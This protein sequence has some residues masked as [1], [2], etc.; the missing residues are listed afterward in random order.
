VVRDLYG[1]I[2][3]LVPDTVSDALIEELRKEISQ[4]LGHYAAQREILIR[5]FENALD[6]E[7]LRIDPRALPVP[8]YPTMRVIDRLA[9][10]TDWL[11]E[12]ATVSTGRRFTFFSVKGGVGRSTAAAVTAWRLAGEGRKILV[13]D[14]DLEAPGIG[15]MLLAENRLPPLGTIDWLIEDGLGAADDV[16]TRDIIARSDIVRGQSELLVIPAFGERSL[17]VP[18]EYLAK[19]GRAV[20]EV[21]RQGRNEGFSGRIARLLDTLEGDEKPDLIIV[22]SRAGLH[23][24]AATALFRLGADAFLFATDSRQTWQDYR[25][26]LAHLQRLWTAYKSSTDLAD[27]RWK[28]KMVH[29]LAQ[30]DSESHKRFVDS[31]YPIWTETLY[32]MSNEEDVGTFGFG[33][34][35]AIAPHYPLRILFEPQLRR[36][37]LSE[38]ITPELEQVLLGAFGLFIDGFRERLEVGEQA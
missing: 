3:I 36:L 24:I 30:P 19:L 37:D 23:E 11:L 13:L 10:G 7:A 21:P 26:L 6:P 2:S 29:A 31:V 12:P 16:L 34:E 35:D 27:W 5:R 28:L 15:G 18:A 9:V 32:E 17:A 4:A 22:D 14:L 20:V 38:E 25:F 8:G 33:L 1:R